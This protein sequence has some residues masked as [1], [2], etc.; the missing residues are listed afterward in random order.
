VCADPNN[1]PFS[2]DRRQGFENRLADIVADDIGAQVVYTWWAQR[3][4][5][6]RNTIDAH[7]CD[8][9]MGV[10]T[11]FE[12]TL[13]TRPYYRSSYAFVWQRNRHLNIASLDDPQLRR[14]RVGVQLVG[15]DGQNTPPAHALARRGITGN[16]AGYTVYGNYVEPNPPARIVDAVVKGDVDVAVVWGPVAG[17]FGAAASRPLV[18]RPVSP[19]RDRT[20]MPLAFDI[21]VG[22]NR[23]LPRLRDDV[24]AA[25]VRRRAE[26]VRLLDA[27]HVPRVANAAAAREGHAR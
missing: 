11:G 9:L 2:N 15:D 14:L 10:P 5:F 24:D 8:V 22:V 1:L 19:Q 16:L 23:A 27:Y 12:R 3:R 6:V 21:S 17:Y 20:G 13:N 25:L 18:V 4:G 7:T 26:V